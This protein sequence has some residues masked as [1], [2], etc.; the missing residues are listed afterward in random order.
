[1]TVFFV[2]F[3]WALIAAVL[4]TGVVMAVLGHFWVLIVGMLL[5]IAGLTKF[6]IYGH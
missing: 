6:G 5:F 1:M 3:L 2:M 4:V